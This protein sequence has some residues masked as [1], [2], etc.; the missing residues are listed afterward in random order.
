MLREQVGDRAEHLDARC[1]QHDQVIAETFEISQQV[2]GEDDGDPLLR[3]AGHQGLQEFTARE[4][5][6][7]GDRLV[8]DEELGPLGEGYRE[9]HLGSLPTRK[10]PNLPVDGDVELHEAIACKDSSHRALRLRPIMR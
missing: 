2:G 10:R 6:Q 8:Q 3:D 4:R 9:R 1:R 5:I 7:A